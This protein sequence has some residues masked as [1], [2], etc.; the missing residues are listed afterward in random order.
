MTLVNG[1]ARTVVDAQDRG[2][3]YG[4]GLFETMRCDQGRVRWFARH[5]RRLELGCERLALPRPDPALVRSEIESLLTA[6][7]RAIAKLI[8]TRGVSAGRGYRPTGDARPTR[9]VAAHAWPEPAATPFRAGLSPVRLGCNPQLAGI[10]HLNRLE[11]V[12]AQQAAR[13]TGLD[14][15]LMGTE[16]GQIVCGSASNLFVCLAD[17]LLTPPVDACG[18]AGV[19]R[20]LVMDAAA[21]LGLALYITPVSAALLAM[22][23]ALFVTN[24]RYGVQPVDWYEGRGLARDERCMRLQEWIDGRF[25]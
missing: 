4:D 23:P 20:S 25:D 14:E 8:L 22:A 15:V 21:Q 17:R 7:P 3:H 12:L 16:S 18:I 24:V 6:R 5:M 1:I 11:Q 10:K 9:I 2:L 19:M 13:A